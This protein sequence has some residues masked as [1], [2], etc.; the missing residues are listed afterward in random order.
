MPKTQ[1]MTK[2]TSILVSPHELRVHDEVLGAVHQVVHVDVGVAD[3]RAAAAL[4]VYLD[5]VLGVG[6]LALDRVDLRHD[7]AVGL[8][9]RGLVDPRHVAAH[10]QLPVYVQLDSEV[11]HDVEDQPQGAYRYQRVREDVEGQPHVVVLEVLRVYEA[12]VDLAVHPDQHQDVDHR[13]ERQ[14]YDLDVDARHQREQPAVAHHRL[15]LEAQEDLVELLE[16]AL[17][18]LGVLLVLYRADH[19]GLHFRAEQLANRV[20]N[21]VDRLQLVVDLDLDVRRV[22][23]VEVEE[24]ELAARL[25]RLFVLAEVDV[26]LLAQKKVVE[27][28]LY[29]L[30]EVVD[31][32]P[33]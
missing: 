6:A 21:E 12:A 10:L 14:K 27:G 5:D 15:V 16:E 19:V 1:N 13:R 7:H 3:V 33:P 32:Q 23:L 2:T 26:Q 20:H 11:E 31:P 18:A 28:V 9:E 8:L 30:V 22:R 4:Q 24:G 17:N 25:G 29:V